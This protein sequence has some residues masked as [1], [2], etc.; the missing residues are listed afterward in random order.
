MATSNKVVV[1]F[2]RIESTYGDIAMAWGIPAR[3]IG[4]GL[5]TCLS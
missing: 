5:A 3:M 2:V 4:T 1:R